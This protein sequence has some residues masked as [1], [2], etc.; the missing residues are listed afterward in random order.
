MNTLSFSPPVGLSNLSYRTSSQMPVDSLAA[1]V[2]AYPSAAPAGQLLQGDAASNPWKAAAFT[3]LQAD[4]A[5]SVTG[6]EEGKGALDYTGTAAGSAADAAGQGAKAAQASAAARAT[7]Q[8]A[9]TGA[10][11]APALSSAGKA[12]KVAGPI[13]TVVSSGIQVFSTGA[14]IRDVR[15]NDK[16]SEAQ[17][18]QKA[19]AA[20]T[21]GAGSIAG[22]LG[23]A[24]AGAAI[25]AA[26][27][28][29]GM[30]IGAVIG[31]L[32]GGKIGEVVGKA[33]GDSPVGEFVGK[34]F[35]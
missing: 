18:E 6:E 9:D 30:I 35:A 32:G 7:A 14:E 26:G 28:P 19:G 33:V 5:R 1:P 17:K 13:G 16:L 8:A 15:N 34:L 10:D 24:A 31:G 25:G 21:E 4:V 22:G 29:P 27:G 23:G 12:A 20:A 2:A 11:V 3:G